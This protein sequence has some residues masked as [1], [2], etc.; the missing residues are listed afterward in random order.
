[1][2]KYP[3]CEKLAAVKEKSQ[4]LGEF[5]SWLRG[6]KEFELAKWGRDDYGEDAL[7]PTHA[8]TE[9]LLAEFFDIDMARVEKEHQDMIRELQKASDA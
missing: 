9:S 1:M 6:N 5:L 8:S 7:M 3:E 4:M 2:G